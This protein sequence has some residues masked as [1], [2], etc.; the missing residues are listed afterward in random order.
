M[1][2]VFLYLLTMSEKALSFSLMVRI[3]CLLDAKKSKKTTWRDV[4]FCFASHSGA[5]QFIKRM[6]SLKHILL[7]DKGVSPVFFRL[8]LGVT[9][10]SLA[11]EEIALCIRGVL[12]MVI[13]EG[14]CIVRTA[15]KSYAVILRY[16]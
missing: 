8:V 7:K 3:V 13:G 16:K 9:Y 11:C 6:V 1:N 14:R 15:R 4:F 2:T 12:V 5:K 10:P